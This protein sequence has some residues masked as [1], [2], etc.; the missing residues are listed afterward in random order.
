[1][2]KNIL[3]V[4]PKSPDFNIFSLFKIPRLGV[5]VLGTLAK[6]AGYNV[7]IVYSEAVALKQEHILWADLVGF[8]MIT[9]TAPEGY[10][11]A[12][13]VKALDKK[14][15]GNRP[16]V[17]GGVHVTFKPEEA[18]EE[19]DYVFR[20]EA[21]MTFVP[22]LDQ[23]NNGG[24]V[25]AIP[26][27]SFYSGERIVH[28]P[29][30][31]ERTSM[32]EVPSPDWS[33]FVDYTPT[34]GIAMTS[35]GCPYDC[36]FCSV[37]PMFGRKYRMRPI[38]LIIED[39]AS[40]ETNNVFFYDDH[41]TAD[42]KR[43]KELLHRIIEERGKRHHVRTFSAQVRSDIAKDPEL[44]DLMAEAG[45]KTLF[46]GLESVNP[47]SLKLYN[48]AQN[49][50]DI[51]YSIKEIHKRKMRI[52]GM[53]VF[54]SDADKM[55]TFSETVRFAKKSEI[56]TVQFLILTPLPG[57]KH[58]AALEREKRI[59]S[60]DWSRYDAFNAVY[61]PKNLS[62]Y[63]LQKGMLRAMKRFYSPLSIIRWLLRGKTAVVLFQL[64]GYITL[65]LWIWNNGRVLKKMKRDSKEIFLPEVMQAPCLH[66]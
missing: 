44:L 40:V 30:P 4:E 18:L 58:Y 2:I 28:N 39:L 37:T 46:I 66:S 50:E 14:H 32:E 17:F 59:L 65:R 57:S 45:F 15:G 34:L 52:H 16:I 5:A 38:D 26:G 11:L 33:L 62:P 43:T 25:S 19:G 54:G 51:I 64:Y 20:G 41:F 10:R 22:F 53:F 21:D 56:E 9:S 6:N 63:E 55:E 49:V 61:L 8:S 12:R 47:E 3:L 13:M 24:D 29:L 31:E 35:R 42:K 60:S 1:M 48:K 23:L 27:V 36:S 7:K